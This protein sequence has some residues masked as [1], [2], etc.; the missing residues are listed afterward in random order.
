VAAA[1]G[2]VAARVASWASWAGVPHCRAWLGAG[3]QQARRMPVAQLAGALLAAGPTLLAVFALLGRPP[4]SWPTLAGLR[5]FVPGTAALAL[6][7]E[8]EAHLVARWRRCDLAAARWW[9]LAGYAPLALAWGLAGLLYLPAVHHWFVY[10]PSVKPAMAIAVLAPA[11]ALKLLLLA[12]VLRERLLAW[13]WCRRYVLAAL[14]YAGA[15]LL[16]KPSL[17]QIDLPGWF[18]PAAREVLAGHLL[19][20]YQLRAD[21]MGTL[22]PLEHG[23]LTPLFYAPFVALAEAAGKS[24][25]LRLGALFPLA[26]VLLVDALMAYQ[27][28]RALHDL[29]PQ[30]SE[31]YRFGLYVVILFSP[32]L[33]FASVWLV[34]LESLQALLAVAALRLLWRG[35]AGWAGAALGVAMLLKHDAAIVAAPLA[36]V[37]ALA[38]RRREALILALVAGAV[39]A[40]GLLPFAIAAPDD[41]AYN[42]FGYDAIKPIYGL[43]IWKAS[44]DSGLEPLIMRWDSLAIG[45]LIIAG[46][47]A[48]GLTWRLSWRGPRSALE[49]G[50]AGNWP[51]LLLCWQGVVLGQLTWLGLATWQYPHYFVTGFVALLVWE[52]AGLARRAAPAT[53]GRPTWRVDRGIATGE[54]GRA[55]PAADSE[56]GWPLLSLLFL[57]VPYNLQA[58]FPSNVGKAGGS[59]VVA[60]AAAQLA[61]LYGCFV[62]VWLRVV[63]VQGTAGGEHSID[64]ERQRK[65]E[66]RRKLAAVE[67]DDRPFLATERHRQA[68]V[69]SSQHPALKLHR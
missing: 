1:N 43:T 16:A 52:T 66:R 60:R 63:P 38:G 9:V 28:T 15:A 67:V 23:P 49:E 55:A 56:A 61:F 53:D 68:A 26:G 31:R 20:I 51:L 22:A 44:Y 36:I 29:A 46:A 27:V 2:R 6:L 35:R 47:V 37:L 39:L 30:L 4:L 33:W 12:M 42:F 21:V 19:R 57:F 50:L 14:A 7:W 5:L 24:D 54:D 25:F 59:F 18:V 34:H 64:V 32:L 40:A 45:L 11:A 62:A 41:F 13:I 8:G 17:W 10:V 69:G 48:L 65:V 58:H 3:L